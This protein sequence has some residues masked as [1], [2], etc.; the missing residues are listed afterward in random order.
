[1]VSKRGTKA[2]G[3]DMSPETASF[4]S[5]WANWVLLAAL[6]IGAVSTGVVIVTGVVKD[7]EFERYKLSVAS[8]V[9]AATQ[10]GI[11][12]GEAAGDAT[13]RTAQANERAANAILEAERL[14]QQLGWRDVTPEQK[15]ILVRA[16]ENERFQV[17][18]HWGMGDGEASMFAHKLAA[19]L[20]NS[21]IEI[22]GGNP[23]GQLGE[24]RHGLSVAGSEAREVQALVAAL[25]KAG[26]GPIE[27]IVVDRS[28]DNTKR[29]D[30]I[31]VGYR[32]PPFLGSGLITSNRRWRR[33]RRRRG[34]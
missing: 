28:P 22:V 5:F 34:S 10:A 16:L 26:Y 33:C 30:D 8:Q 29:F 18:F 31:F 12:A 11:T 7:R 15:A 9:A 17:A 2:I 19:A 13:V 4:L 6:I 24:E 3:M 25:T 21:G 32:A 27:P 1:M 14:K 20:N 23:I